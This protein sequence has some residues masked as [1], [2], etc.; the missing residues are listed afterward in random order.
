MGKYLGKRRG[1]AIVPTLLTLGNG[2]CG[3]VAIAKTLDAVRCADTPLFEGKLTQ[4]ALLIFLAMVFDALDGR[5]ARLTH[6]TTEFG[7][8][9]DSFT[10]L[11]SFGLA[12]AL[13]V[14]TIYEQSLIQAEMVYSVKLTLLLTALYTICSVL[15]LA[16]FTVDTSPEESSHKVFVGLPTPAAAGV[17]AST[18]LFLNHGSDT[19][20]FIRE[21]LMRLSINRALLFI[22]P[23]LGLLMICKIEYVHFFNKFVRGRKTFNFLVQGV[24]CLFIVGFWYE[25][26]VLFCFLIYVFS[27]P[28]LAVYHLAER[29]LKGNKKTAHPFKEKK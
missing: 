27:G 18:V 21:P 13:L 17:I 4:A 25:W 15:R 1:I 3:F 22:P 14:K 9:L 12:P 23:L 6:Q 29:R 11:I 20:A 7:A 8:Q 2:F 16:R 26:A 19:F 28:V 5:V 10:D 24:L